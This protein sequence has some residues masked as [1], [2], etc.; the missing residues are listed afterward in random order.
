LFAAA[1]PSW[2]TPIRIL[3]V[4]HRLFTEG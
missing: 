2:T 4:D 3:L 1:V